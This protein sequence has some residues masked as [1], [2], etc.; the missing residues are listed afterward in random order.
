MGRFGDAAR[1]LLGQHDREPNLDSMIGDRSRRNQAVLPVVTA[2]GAFKNSVWWA[3]LRLRANLMSTFPIDVVRERDGVLVPV[4]SPGRLF[5]SPSP[6]VDITEFLYSRQIDLD[7]YGNAVGIIRE[8]N[9]LGLPAVIELQLMEQCKAQMSG[10]RVEQWKIGNEYYQPR[11][12]WH[13]KQY[14]M[15]GFGLGLAPLAYAAYSMG[16]YASAQE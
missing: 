6:G 15:A 5:S 16:I 3:G 13:E 14:T 12:I 8:R 4:P 10:G 11:D 9:A 7:R 1:I 2:E